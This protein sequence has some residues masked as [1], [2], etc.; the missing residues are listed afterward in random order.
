MYDVYLTMRQEW[1]LEKQEAMMSEVMPLMRSI[2]IGCETENK[3]FWPLSLAQPAA[4][5]L[6]SGAA[7]DATAHEEE[8][9][10]LGMLGLLPRYNILPSVAGT[11]MPLLC[12]C[13]WQARH[14]KM[15]FFLKGSSL[16]VFGLQGG[17]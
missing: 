7:E 3:A 17:I 14:K 12:P 5:P 9:G 16:G 11:T 10:P 15:M 1:E 6:T 4:L 2:A 13:V 8:D